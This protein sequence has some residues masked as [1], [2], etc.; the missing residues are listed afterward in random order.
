MP[1]GRNIQSW[2]ISRGYSLSALAAKA[3]LPPTVLEVIESEDSDPSVSM[4]ECVALA[5]GIPAA[6]LFGDP[7]Q[8]ALLTTDPD[9]DVTEAP[10]SH[11]LDPALDQI[12]AGVQQ[13]RELYVLLTVLIQSDDPR[14]IRAA[15][16]SL[17]SL[18]KQARRPTVPWQSRPSG[19]FEPPS[20]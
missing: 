8:F 11:S 2:R 9:G 18:A 3:G 20:D 4:L 19:H 12:L 14:I 17:R 6:W 15:E 13:N 16:A 1:L 10:A 7:R 5:I